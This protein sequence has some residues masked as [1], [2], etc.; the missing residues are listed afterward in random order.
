MVFEEAKLGDI[1]SR[2][3]RGV[4]AEINAMVSK[5]IAG[6][7]A[8]RP[9][10]GSGAKWPWGIEQRL[11]AAERVAHW[12]DTQ[13]KLL[14]GNGDTLGVDQAV[15]CSDPTHDINGSRYSLRP[16]DAPPCVG[17]ILR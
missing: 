7:D 3:E 13:V 11:D 4:D 14:C 2:N 5:R 8:K 9:G 1:G 10:S 15:G 17:E 16:A 6:P 12:W